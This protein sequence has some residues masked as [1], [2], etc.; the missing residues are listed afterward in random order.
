MVDAKQTPGASECLWTARKD[1]D[2]LRCDL[3]HHGDSGWELQL[4]CNEVLSVDAWLPS[5]TVA[6]DEA[7]RICEHYQVVGWAV[8][9]SSPVREA[10]VEQDDH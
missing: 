7:W 5:R 10:P 4:Y 9:A 8:T 3:R 2:A 6:I 1:N